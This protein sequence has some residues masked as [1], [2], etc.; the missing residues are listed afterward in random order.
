MLK[1]LGLVLKISQTPPSSKAMDQPLFNVGV[2]RSRL[3]DIG[4]W[5]IKKRGE[6]HPS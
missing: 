1:D 6:K 5:D 3:L 2:E 4:I